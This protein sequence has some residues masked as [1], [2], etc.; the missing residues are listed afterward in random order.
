MGGNLCC[1][2]LQSTFL[3]KSCTDQMTNVQLAVFIGCLGNIN[4]KGNF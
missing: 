3:E 4:I 1:S 2:M